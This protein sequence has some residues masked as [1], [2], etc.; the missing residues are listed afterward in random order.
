MSC[1][2]PIILP[3]ITNLSSYIHITIYIHTH[4]R[5]VHPVRKR[6]MLTKE[7]K[8]NNNKKIN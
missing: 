7:K 3:I 5:K 4:T 8:K 2:F 1:K 6:T